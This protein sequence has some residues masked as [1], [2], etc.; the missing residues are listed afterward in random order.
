M[1]AHERNSSLLERGAPENRS[2]PERGIEAT[3]RQPGQQRN[4]GQTDARIP[5]R[6][7]G[8]QRKFVSRSL[9]SP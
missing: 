5:R 6:P 7:L 8:R 9:K 1:P 3:E 4:P 2:T